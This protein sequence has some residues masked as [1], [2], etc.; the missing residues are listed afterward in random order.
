LEEDESVIM[1]DLKSRTVSSY[2]VSLDTSL[3]SAEERCIVNLAGPD[4][5]VVYDVVVKDP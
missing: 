5:P 4:L 1:A 3:S 2:S